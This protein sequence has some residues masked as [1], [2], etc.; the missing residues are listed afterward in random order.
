[1]MR[2]SMLLAAAV[3]LMV[4]IGVGASGGD[5]G[6]TVVSAM[7]RR[8]RLAVP[9]TADQA[10]ERSLKTK[11]KTP[12]VKASTPDELELDDSNSTELGDEKI[13]VNV[14]AGGQTVK[15]EAD[16]DTKDC[17]E[18]NEVCWEDPQCCSG[19]CATT[20]TCAPQ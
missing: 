20:E 11:P 6:F 9:A 14:T 19:R 1:M 13:S 7:Y 18:E 16:V 3:A 2:A 17:K 4:P 15:V 10:M 8:L 5:D 12:I